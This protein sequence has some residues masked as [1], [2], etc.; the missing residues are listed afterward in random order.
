M[1][2][3]Q[4]SIPIPHHSLCVMPMISHPCRHMHVSNFLVCSPY[5]VCLC[6]GIWARPLIKLEQLESL[7]SARGIHPGCPKQK[8]TRHSPIAFHTSSV[9]C[10][11]ALLTKLAFFFFALQGKGE[12]RGIL[13]LKLLRRWETWK[14]RRW[15]FHVSYLQKFR[16][17]NYPS[18]SLLASTVCDGFAIQSSVWLQHQLRVVVPA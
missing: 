10:V 16:S 9:V 7:C 15:V 13:Q 6:R 18:S 17:H 8:H 2:S 5:C 11:C 14:T 4:P 1:K 3:Q 12:L